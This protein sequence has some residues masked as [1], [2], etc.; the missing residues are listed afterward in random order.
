MPAGSGTLHVVPLPPPGAGLV[1]E[2]RVVRVGPHRV[3]VQRHERHVVALVEDLLGA[4]AVVVV[5]VEHGDPRAAGRRRRGAA[6]I[7][8]LLKK[9]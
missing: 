9:Q 8:A 2:A 4:V 3:A 5:D 7:A 6:A 1:G